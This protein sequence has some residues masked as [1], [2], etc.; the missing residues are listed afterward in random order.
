VTE[1]DI[2][3]LMRATEFVRGLDEPSL[4]RLVPEQSGLRFVG[5]PNCTGGR[6]EGQLVWTPEHPDEVYCRYCAHRYPSEKYPMNAAVTVRSPRK[7]AVRFP[8]WENATGYRYFFRARRDAL[9]RDYLASRCQDLA[10]LYY[11]T[12]ERAY[13]RRAAL[14]MYRFAQVFPGWCYHYDYPFQ[15]KEIYDGDV[16]PEKFRRGFRTARWDWWAYLDIPTPLVQAYDWIRESGIFADLARERGE[17]VAAQIERDL[18]RNAAEQVLANPESYG[19]MSPIAW[20]ALV[21][22]GRVIG[23]P[24]Y[25]HEPVRRLRQFVGTRFFYDGTW[26]EGAPSYHAQSVGGLMTVL[27]LLRG[28]SDPPAY[29]DPADGVR[30]DDLDL[31]ASFP[32]LRRANESLLKM[33]LPNGR[34]VPVHDTW[35]TNRRDPLTET[36]PYLLPALGH[37]CLGGG[38]GAAQTQLHLTWSGGYGHQHGDNLSLLLFAQDREMLSDLGYSHTAYRAWTQATA[39]HN[40]V[41]IDGLSQEFGGRGE[42]TDGSLRWYDARDPRVQVVSATGERAYP[43]KASLY[44]RSLVLINAGQGRSYAVD[45]FEVEGGRIHDYFLHG[46]A[47]APSSV[48]T[49]LPL[50][51]LATLLPPGFDWRATQNEGETGRAREPHYAYGFL[52]SL[53]A[54][55]A[56]AGAALPVTFSPAA[57]TGPR[58]R[59]TLFPGANSRLLLGENPSIR[60]AGEDDSKLDAFTRPFLALRREAAGGHSAF[61]SVLE[62]YATAPFLTSIERLPA[63]AATVVLRVQF[64]DRTDLIVLGASTPVSLPAGGR[65]TTFQGEV[66]VLSLRGERVEHAFA[67]GAGGWTRGAFRL[68]VDGSQSW[69]LRLVQKDGFTLAGNTTVLPQAGEIVRLHTGNGWIYPYTVA[70]AERAGDAIRLRVVEGPDLT[71]DAEARRL[72]LTAYPQREH[73]GTARLEWIPARTWR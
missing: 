11:V 37:A 14:I 72:R 51:P 68:R 8:Y 42:A 6:Q 29:V 44:R 62:P 52:R 27:R 48:R 21:P 49:S 66:G 45:L 9:V 57:E 55:P 30:F 38:R 46:D 53:R 4:L 32:A 34:L 54:A 28:Y 67:L 56:P 20:R 41:V 60:P 5:C 22:L 59:V 61:V 15:Q 23:E 26:P 24:R 16:P 17:D 25:V 64:G 65:E 13:A 39:A 73:T 47:D 12:K 40:T 70:A 35:S 1:R 3:E 2:P 7:E 18:F 19:N 43:G 33:R 36:Q 71:F 10:R 63:P 69:G 31:E 50:E 58:L